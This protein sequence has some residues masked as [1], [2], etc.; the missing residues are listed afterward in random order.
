MIRA[1]VWIDD[2]LADDARQAAGLGSVSLPRLIRYAL[3]KLAG[4]PDS[5]ARAVARI[6]EEGGGHAR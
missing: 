5:A 6:R 1:R 3:A 4:W 2:S